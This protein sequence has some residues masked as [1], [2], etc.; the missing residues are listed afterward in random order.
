MQRLRIYCTTPNGL[1]RHLLLSFTPDNKATDGFDFGYDGLN[2]D[3]FPDDLSWIIGENRFVIQGVGA[4]DDTKKYPLDLVLKNQGDVSINLESLENFDTPINVFIY[5]ALLNTYTKIN[6]S[7]YK[8][9]FKSG[10]YK[11]RLYVAFKA[12]EET[13]TNKSLSVNEENLE[14]TVIQYLKNSKELY[15]NTNNNTSVQAISVFRINGQ[16]IYSKN[17][18]DSSVIKIPFNSL[19]LN[20]YCIINV[21]TRSGKSFRKIILSQ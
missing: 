3:K 9:N 1:I 20:E 6:E 19:I 13:S 18:L 11:N 5:D 10:N 4:F 17:N 16:L 12:S 2:L 14:K 15:I 8:Y 7:N 21:Q